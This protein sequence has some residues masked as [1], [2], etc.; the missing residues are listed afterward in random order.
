MPVFADAGALLVVS[1]LP[2]LSANPLFQKDGVLVEQTDDAR[3]VS[4]AWQVIV[5][6]HPPPPPELT[7]W[8]EQIET[9][10]DSNLTWGIANDEKALWR[11]KIV[12]MFWSSKVNFMDTHD[13]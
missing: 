13:L 1:L 6:L 8:R 2:L 11:A 5:I 9:L 7:S 10:I 12:R 4:G 3:T